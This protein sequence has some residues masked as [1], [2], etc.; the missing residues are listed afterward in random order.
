MDDAYPGRGIISSK[1]RKLLEAC[2]SEREKRIQEVQGNV[3]RFVIEGCS[4]ANM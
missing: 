1:N 3:N 2:E 4:N